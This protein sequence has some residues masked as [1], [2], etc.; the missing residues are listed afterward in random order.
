MGASSYDKS[1]ISRAFFQLGITHMDYIDS[2]FNDLSYTVQTILALLAVAFILA[3]LILLPTAVQVRKFGIARLPAI[4]NSLLGCSLIIFSIDV[5]DV[6]SQG[7]GGYFRPLFLA[8]VLGFT[9]NSPHEF[10]VARLATWVPLFIVTLAVRLITP[11]RLGLSV[12][13]IFFL[14]AMFV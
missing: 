10:V 13:I 9:V 4:S 7:D 12:T 5:V 3:M 14:F 2:I 6:A 11:P 1:R 8:E